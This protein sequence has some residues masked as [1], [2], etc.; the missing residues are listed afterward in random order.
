MAVSKTV[1]L[2]PAESV[3]SFRDPAGALIRADKAVYRWVREAYAPVLTRFLASTLYSE[4]VASGDLIPTTAVSN[5]AEI[6][7]RLLDGRSEGLLLEHERV[8]FPSYPYEW[9]PGMLHASA[10]LT[11]KLAER[12]L[13][14]GFGLKDATPYNVLFRGPNPVFVD[15]LSFEERDPA[16]PI[17]L[18]N[19]QFQ[20]MFVLPLLLMKHFG[21]SAAEIF[22]GRPEGIEPDV[23]YRRCHP[24]QRLSPS[25]LTSVSLPTWLA[26]RGNTQKENL[27][28]ARKTDPEKAKYILGFRLRGLRKQLDRFRP[29]GS[30][31]SVWSDYMSTLSYDDEDFRCK[32]ETVDRWLRQTKPESV[33]DAGCNTGHFSELAAKQNARVVAIDFDPMV[34]ESVRRR[35]L[36]NKLNILPLVVNL[37]RPTPACGWR[38]LEYSSF[39]D[40]AT[41]AFDT[42]LMLALIHHLLVTERVPLPEIIDLAATMTKRYAII[43]YVGKEDSMFRTLTRG[44]E[45]LHADF[46]QERFEEACRQRFTIEEKQPL[47]SNLRCLYLLRARDTQ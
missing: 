10:E 33:L 3:S 43:E 42:V 6:R 5:E 25:F 21:T 27:Y 30:G 17:W 11:L 46:T 12:A 13:E 41:Q 22:L 24:L 34:V 37:A 23:V 8:P 36:S 15:V 40:R 26:K 1:V 44:R 29:Q 47:M 39:V 32:S 38:N 35:A 14:E 4:G 2:N 18:P 45:S 31:K 19:A 20:R 16:D 9:S 7:D 28:A